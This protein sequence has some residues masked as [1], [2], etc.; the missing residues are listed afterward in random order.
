MKMRLGTKKRRVFLFLNTEE[1]SPQKWIHDGTPY[2][3]RVAR[4]KIKKIKRV[5]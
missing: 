4:K 3:K 1:N 5:R 2:D